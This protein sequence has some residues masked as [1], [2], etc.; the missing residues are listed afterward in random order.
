[1]G[2][3]TDSVGRHLEGVNRREIAILTNGVAFA[4]GAAEPSAAE[5][6][7]LSERFEQIR[8]QIVGTD[9]RL[10]IDSYASSPGADDYKTTPC[11]TVRQ[12]D[13]H[14]SQPVLHSRPHCR[15]RFR[16]IEEPSPHRGLTD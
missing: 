7:K 16:Y 12:P 13:H 4:F 11:T 2:D 9:K 1:M 3:A 14:G 8:D 6:L 15:Y 10:L 5:I